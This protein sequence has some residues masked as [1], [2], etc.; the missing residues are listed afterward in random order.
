MEKDL[1][2]EKLTLND[3]VNIEVYEEAIDF[4]FSSSD[5]RNIAISGAYGA[6]KSS[7]LASYKKKHKEKKFM[8]ISLAH[9]EDENKEESD[10]QAQES[11][12]EGKI[13]NQLIHQIA[14]N[15]IPQTNFK[16]KQAVGKKQVVGITSL[17]LLAAVSL[18]FIVFY[19]NWSSFI[20][21]FSGWFGALLGLSLSPYARLVAGIA[22][23]IVLCFVTYQLI[24]LQKNKKLF[25][26]VNV[27]G[28]E[29]EIFENKEESYFDKYLNEVLYLFE[30]SNVDAIVFEDMDRFEINRI[31]ERLREVNTLVN[32][33]LEKKSQ[34]K[35]LR[36]IYLLRDDVFVSK[37]RTKFFDYIVPIVP[38]LDGT[39]SYDQF[40]LHLQRNHM[41]D[42]LNGKFLQGLSLYVD[43][44][45]LLKNICNEFLVYYNRVNTTELNYNKMFALITYKNLFPRDFSDLQLGRGFICA[46]FAQKYELIKEREKSIQILIDSK[47]EEIQFYE[48]ENL[49]SIAELDIIKVDK[50]RLINSAPY[51]RERN[52]RQS[53]YDEW[54]RNVYPKRKQAIEDKTLDRLSELQKELDE[55]QI[56]LLKTQTSSL[57][58]LIT[59]DN[60]DE[61]FRITTVN[62][63]GV[64]ETYDE[65]KSSEYFDL[66]KYLVRN[67]YVDETY[68]DYM[69]YFYE[70][71]LS[72]IDK[73]FLRSVTD[74]KA[75]EYTYELKDPKLVVSRLDI[76]DFDEKE[77]L[78]FYLLK[79]LIEE[80]PSSKQVSRLIKQLSDNHNIDFIRQF[81]SYFRKW[82][83]YVKALN[84]LWPSLFKEILESNSFTSKMIHE[85]SIYTLYSSTPEILCKIDIDSCFTNYIA[86]SP[87]Y[88]QIES[89]N[90]DKL[91]PVFESLGIKFR[92]INFT[93]AD[94]GLFRAVYEHSLYELNF[95]NIELM[96]SVM[97]QFASKEEIQHRNYSLVI[98]DK[99]SPLFKYVDSNFGK[100]MEEILRNCENSID[101]ECEV[102]LEIINDTRISS[103][104]KSKYISCLNTTID[105]LTA[106]VDVN[107]WD[108][109]LDNGVIEFS[110]SNIV[111]YYYSQKRFTSSLI[112][113]INEYPDDIDMT[114]VKIR[115]D[116]LKS[117]LFTAC[118]KSFEI[119]NIKYRQILFSM[120][121]VYRENFPV[122]NVPDDK[123]KILIDGNIISMNPKSM[124]TIRESYSGVS[125]YFI[126]SNFDVYVNM[127]T[128][129]M[130]SFDELKRI[131][132]W[133]VSDEHKIA[134][135]AFSSDSISVVGKAYSPLVKLSILENNLEESD[136]KHLR[137]EYHNQ[138]VEIK[139]FILND[140]IKKVAQII[141]APQDVSFA[142]IEELLGTTNLDDTDKVSLL[143]ESIPLMSR[144]QCAHAFALIG[145]KEFENIFESRK[146]PKFAVCKENE[147]ILIKIKRKGWIYEYYIDPT[148]DENYR[149][150][151][152]KPQQKLSVELL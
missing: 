25:K 149:I 77:T 95:S 119:E 30:N 121:R 135:L 91:I 116:D 140:A 45:R 141:N 33:Q 97:E 26:R 39:N 63:I 62:E 142:L 84:N 44:M 151:R 24:Q 58:E 11:I 80:M 6:G 133:D 96:L 41:I 46:L 47:S 111:S 2:F 144:E 53:E 54:F 125:D 129:D 15:N 5:V 74:K 118:L 3:D 40:I 148:D 36:F 8:H 29:I 61:V 132:D 102:A 110:E 55:L 101:D 10:G 51:G 19:D 43:D 32:V 146:K 70:N 73:I 94:R 89:P 127:M 145:R 93:V 56:K 68:A 65:I 103:E 17:F 13:L 147:E 120:R 134:L 85:F 86:L 79:F 128:D 64:E 104:N 115:D 109:C 131:L 114:K 69:T 1:H 59:R 152:H 81:F 72:R 52:Q 20:S 49:I 117:E 123:M 57:K 100:Y 16:I 122:E 34:A 83:H 23:L 60:V 137:K 113:Y 82:D 7:V 75:K 66:L 108:Q 99:E 42:N 106:I 112:R 14:P 71:S 78:N 37:D 31:F 136:L 130:F 9:F 87:D 88:L 98:K 38:V 90:V 143:T 27:Q 22:L 18:L 105:S 35:P 48:N 150:R 4:A 12:L 67:G 76:S 92:T 50:Q 28:T 138:S 126:Q 124:K 139:L 21:N 107:L